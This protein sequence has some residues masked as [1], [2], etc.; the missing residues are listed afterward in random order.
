V[1]H[2]TEKMHK[3]LTVLLLC[4]APVWKRVTEA[5]FKPS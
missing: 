3:I 5:R 2:G 4:M 1:V